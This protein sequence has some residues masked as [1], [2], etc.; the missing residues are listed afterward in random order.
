MKLNMRYLQAA[1][2]L[3][4]ASFQPQP[5][6]VERQP[7]FV[8]KVYQMGARVNQTDLLEL[9]AAVDSLVSDARQGRMSVQNYYEQNPQIAT[10]LA[11]SLREQATEFAGSAESLVLML[12]PKE[13]INALD[14]NSAELQL[15]KA[16]KMAQ[17]EGKKLVSLID[18]LTRETEVRQT[19][20][21]RIAMAH[22]LASGN[23]A[24][25]KWL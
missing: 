10:E 17:I 25:A 11:L 16:I 9:A 18:Q 5:E 6:A 14:K 24:A 19:D 20:V 23:Q 7:G 3:A 15:I 4:L 8:E 21:D 2:A 1:V 22:L 13:V 12:P